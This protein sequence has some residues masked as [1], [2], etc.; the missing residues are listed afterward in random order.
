M[1]V[2]RSQW[3][4][5]NDNNAACVGDDNDADETETGDDNLTPIIKFSPLHCS[6]S[7]VSE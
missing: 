4:T 6:Y 1:Y 5:Y 2:A 3:H 7:D